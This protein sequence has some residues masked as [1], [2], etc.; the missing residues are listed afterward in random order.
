MPI[1]LR[2]S[3]R[4][5]STSIHSPQTRVSRDRPS[6][7]LQLAIGQ[8][9][10]RAGR[11]SAVGTYRD[12]LPGRFLPQ[13][14]LDAFQLEPEGQGFAVDMSLHSEPLAPADARGRRGYLA[15]PAS[16]HR[17]HVERA[18]GGRVQPC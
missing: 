8:A 11:L 4:G 17:R 7:M 1:L 15:D 13:S 16:T 5:P 10:Q 9:F 18:G 6:A 3:K 2:A 14:T 12:A